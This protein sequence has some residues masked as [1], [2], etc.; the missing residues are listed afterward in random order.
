MNARTRARSRSAMSSVVRSVVGW[1]VITLCVPTEVAADVRIRFVNG[2]DMI[3]R[4]HW[5]AGT[6]TWFT[7]GRGTIGVPHAFVAAIEPVDAPRGIGGGEK[8]VN[9]APRLVAPDSVR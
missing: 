7:K 2:R 1:I 5:Y 8:A 3:V 6:Q 4:E 9:A